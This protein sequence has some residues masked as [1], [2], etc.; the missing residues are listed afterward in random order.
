[1][2]RSSL[3]PSVLLCIQYRLTALLNY[4]REALL[5]DDRNEAMHRQKPVPSPG[6]FPVPQVRLCSV[7]PAAWIA[8]RAMPSLLAGEGRPEPAGSPGAWLSRSGS[9]LSPH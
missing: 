5:T 8:S 3:G 4:I 7:E 1:M 6:Q 9:A 2:K